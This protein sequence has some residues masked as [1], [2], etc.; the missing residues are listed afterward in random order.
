MIIRIERSGGVAGIPA[1][2]EMEVNELP[3]ELIDKLFVKQN[4]PPPRIKLPRV[5][6]PDRYTYRISIEEAGDQKIIECDE[7]DIANDVKSLV[8]YIE[9]NSRAQTFRA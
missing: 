7:Y 4:S 1:H 3:A 2:N 9:K 5:G 8:K 6:R